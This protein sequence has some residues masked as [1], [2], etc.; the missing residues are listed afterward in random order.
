M[1]YIYI[2]RYNI[3]SITNSQNLWFV[4]GYYG[5]RWSSR[6]IVV[7]IDYY[8]EIEVI[9][10]GVKD[11]H[12]GG[13]SNCRRISVFDFTEGSPWKPDLW[14]TDI[15]KDQNLNSLCY[16]CRNISQSF[17]LSPYSQTRNSVSSIRIVWDYENSFSKFFSVG[18]NTII[19]ILLSYLV[20]T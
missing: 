12:D 19:G 11:R 1:S 10:T 9:R 20:K 8:V 3:K 18:N 13:M 16:F 2:R 4:S 14:K 17:T 5:E 6:H 15:I 7:R